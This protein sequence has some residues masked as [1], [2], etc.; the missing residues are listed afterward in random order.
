MSDC[1]D[2]ELAIIILADG[3]RPDVLS[4]LAAAGE[5]P[6][7]AESFYRGGNS[8][9]GVTVLPSVSSVAYV[10]MLTGQYPGP[11][12]VPGLRWVEKSSFTRGKKLFLQGHRSY[13]A[14][15]HLKMDEDLSDDLETLFELNPDSLGVR[16]DIRRGLS[17]GSKAA[18]QLAFMPQMFFAHYMRRGDFVDRGVM[19]QALSWLHKTH[20]RRPRFIFLPLVDVDKVSHRYGPEHAR[21]LKAYRHID[22]L[23]GK[24][25]EL[26]RRQG[27]WKRTHLMI[28]SDH[29]HTE[30][31]QHLDMTA[32]VSE[33]GYSVFE[34]PN[35]YRRSADAAVMISGNSFGNIYLSTD[36]KWEAPLTSEELE[37]EHGKVLRSLSQREEVEWF[38]YRG[39][40]TEVKIVSGCGESVLGLDDGHYT[41]AF[42]GSD[43]LQLG[44]HHNRVRRADSLEKTAE[45]PFPDALEQLWHLFQS[46]RTGDIIVTAKPGYDLRGWREFPEH[47]SS[48]GALCR[49]HMAV[50][51]LSN[52]PLSAVSDGLARTVDL[53]PTVVEGLGLSP[54]VPH[55]GR[56]L[57]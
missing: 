23:V 31:R 52:I 7:I 16:C 20:D 32:L 29:G 51:I 44:L 57:L 47:R 45:S 28:T 43:P 36:R 12:D 38:A 35:V 26:L 13:I 4:K 15:G 2:I 34:Y 3:V 54:A 41:Y 1:P 10:P 39:M 25:V 48:H 21:T 8:Y 19:A 18:G 9:D 55:F 5:L 49:D 50:P 56:S 46:E 14:P 42:N 30:T 40:N 11:A 24:L 53:F 33:L 6:N 37:R 27:M 17:N 22:A